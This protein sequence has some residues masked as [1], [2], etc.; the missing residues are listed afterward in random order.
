M[1]I[2]KSLS[3][4]KG[5]IL[6]SSKK[7][8]SKSVTSYLPRAS[9]LETQGSR[10]E[11]SY[12]GMGGGGI[13]SMSGVSVNTYWPSEYQYM[14]SGLLAGA[15]PLSTD[16]QSLAL[17]YRDIYLL[18]NTAGSA[19]DIQS[20][21]PFSDFEL[22]GLSEDKLK[23]FQESIDQLNLR[24]MMPEISIAYLTDG[25]FCGSLIFDGKSK[26]FLDT[27][28]HDALSCQVS[29]SPFY[30]V[31]PEINVRVGYAVER[32]LQSGSVFSRRYLET[33]PQG[34]RELLAQGSFTLEP[35]STLFIPRKTITDRAYVSYLH[36]ILPM[37]LIEKTLYRGTLTEAHRRQ[38]AMTQIS[39]GDDNW[40]PSP[41]ELQALVQQYQAAEMDPLGGWVSTHQSVTTTDLRCLSGDTWI[42]TDR[43][44]IRL[45]DLV[46][47]NPENLKEGTRFDAGFQALNHKGVYAPVKY[48]WYQ[49]YKP[50]E[51]MTLNDGTEVV[52]TKNHRFVTVDEHMG[53][54]LVKM[55]DINEETW[56]LKPNGGSVGIPGTL[57]YNFLIK[58]RL[59]NSEHTFLNDEG[60]EV[61]VPLW[62]NVKNAGSFFLY[63]NFDKGVYKDHLD[64]LKI[65]SL[66]AY[67]QV[68]MFV[69][70][71]TVFL[72]AR[73]I[74]PAGME[75]VYDLTMDDS[76]PPV[77]LAN[78]VA[79]K[80]SAG[81][82]WKWTDVV[83]TMVSYK[84]RALG[85][86]ES[87]LS[88]DSSYASSESA[89][90]TFLESQDAYRNFLTDKTFYSKIFPLIAF[91][92]GFF[93][94]PSL[95]KRSDDITPQGFLYNARNRANLEIPTVYWYKQLEADHEDGMVDMLS[96]LDEQ[97]IPVPL[98]MWMAAAGVDSDT[99]LKDLHD[100]QR[101][102]K[103]LEEL[104]GKDVEHDSLA[105]DE[106]G[107]EEAG[108]LPTRSLAKSLTR[109]KVPILSREWGSSGDVYTMNRSGSGKKHVYN[110]AEARKRQNDHIIKAARRMKNPN[111]RNS[112]KKANERIFGTSILKSV[113][114]SIY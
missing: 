16:S 29:H 28:V 15:D 6:T 23:V 83:D 26:T 59:L 74:V 22:R 40:E 105:E 58:R 95:V 85:I 38:R 113:Q 86:S 48:W 88:G 108:V 33:I 27:M 32:F 18:D 110:Q 36:R 103:Q 70:T 35:L 61:E 92:N 56:L 7:D 11:A 84:L 114:E 24:R 54:T 94:D 44:N 2:S 78:G 9:M 68:M 52:G 5:K 65:V 93:K 112:V 31:D 101:L 62:A 90:Q 106:Y 64:I 17:M 30:N 3:V 63:D 53:L 97:G 12:A 91:V 20:T 45:K 100:D 73:S 50:V 87:F 42:N 67:N 21:F 99:L 14:L 81:D 72:Q 89:Y 66:R 57:I 43:G 1:F 102:R 75:H 82:F 111:Y 96:L 51:R 10:V 109:R 37:Y 76:V 8:N 47:H 77:F 39:A 60:E 41:E 49:G 79:S 104:T 69:Q 98:K 19:V 4:N 25:Y 55:E 107:Y 34:F 71:R 46:E 13:P 80:N